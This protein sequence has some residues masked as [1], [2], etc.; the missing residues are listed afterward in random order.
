MVIDVNDDDEYKIT[1]AM[2]EPNDKRRLLSREADSIPHA[3][4][5]MDAGTSKKIF[6]GLTKVIILTDK[7]I[8]NKKLFAGALDYLE[9]TSEINKKTVVLVTKDDCEKILKDNDFDFLEYY[10]NNRDFIE[11]DLMT[12]ISRTLDGETVEIPRIGIVDDEV[13]FIVE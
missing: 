5:K 4:Q 9:F 3:I 11:L 2:A 10:A 13:A 7:L 12:L 6:L 8:D 1:V